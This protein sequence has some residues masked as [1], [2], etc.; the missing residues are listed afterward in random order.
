MKKLLRWGLVMMVAVAAILS[1]LVGI[2]INFN[3]D[4]MTKL[5]PPT[6]ADL[7]A[8]SEWPGKATPPSDVPEDP[9]VRPAHDE[10]NSLPTRLASTPSLEML[11]ERNAERYRETLSHPIE[12]FSMRLAKPLVQAWQATLH[13]TGRERGWLWNDCAQVHAVLGELDAARRC[14][15]RVLDSSEPDARR[16]ACAELAWYEEEPEMA[17][18][19]LEIS[20]Q[21]GVGEGNNLVN[22]IE[23]CRLTGST[24]L[25]D[26][27]LDRLRAE[28][29]GR[30]RSWERDWEGRTG[31][32]SE[33]LADSDLPHD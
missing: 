30:A 23:L 28:H 29:G 21:E 27:Y 16:F 6:L 7:D 22:A 26:H 15:W 11:A 33:G 17:A 31:V 5:T 14:W 25:A 9:A 13:L 19:L 1:V 20:C 32:G 10:L 18:R 4:E 8:L 3:R 24:K 2:A 12:M